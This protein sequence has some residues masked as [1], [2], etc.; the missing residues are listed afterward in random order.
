MNDD[1]A[2]STPRS[3]ELSDNLPV[4]SLSHLDVHVDAPARVDVR[5]LSI[6]THRPLGSAHDHEPS[7][8]RQ[9]V[10]VGIETTDG[11]IGWGEC[12]ALN[13]P[14]YTHEWA[15]DSF[16][17]LAAW[18]DGGDAPDAAELP[19]T[20]AA[21]EMAT[22]DATLKAAG[23]SLASAIGAGATHVTAGA[24]IGLG[25][26]GP[27]VEQAR[28]LV[29]LGYRKLKVKID[30]SQVDDVA[31]ALSHELS[32]VEIHVDA[33]GSLDESHLMALLGLAYHGVTAIEQPFAVDRPDLAAEL[34]LG[35]DAIV[36]ADEGAPSQRDVEELLAAS[37]V[38]AVAIKPPR[39]GG[40]AA[41]VELVEWCR[42]STVGASIGGLLE[43]GLGRHA[44]AAVAGLDGFT[45]TGD[46]SPAGQ[47]LAVDPWPDLTMVDGSIVVPEGPGV[48][49]PPDLQLLDRLTQ[50]SAGR[51]H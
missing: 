34:M 10:V 28:S 32:D 20:A 50:R 6:P 33:N 4:E 35:T 31:H 41:A 9:L 36:I 5:L 51:R 14:T 47:W 46:L 22:L 29:D 21:L 26:V 49:P 2:I 17:R 48:A 1:G 3:G 40:I 43:C 37:A 45:V 16:E 27:S 15:E 8:D 30:P 44:L 13:A 19:M 38:R 11:A 7:S 18:A 24:T 39:L 12:S 25:P 23:R 42:R